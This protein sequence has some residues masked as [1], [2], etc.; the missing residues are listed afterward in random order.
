MCATCGRRPRHFQETTFR[1]ETAT[2][3]SG[4]RALTGRQIVARAL[5][6]LNRAQ[7]EVDD[8]I[9]TQMAEITKKLTELSRSV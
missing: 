9:Q 1:P 3:R 5:P 4:L 6:L 2:T 7:L 8:V